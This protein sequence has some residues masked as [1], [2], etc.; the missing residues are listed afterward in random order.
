MENIDKVIEDPLIGAFL[1]KYPK[2]EWPD[3]LKKALKLGIYS[4]NTLNTLNHL[5]ISPVKSISIIDIDG[6]LDDES[7]TALADSLIKTQGT[8]ISSQ[9]GIQIQRNDSK[10]PNKKK[11]NLSQNSKSKVSRVTPKA[12]RSRF[13]FCKENKDNKRIKST[14]NK[15][16]IEKQ[17]LEFPKETPKSHEVMTVGLKKN[18]DDEKCKENNCAKSFK[19]LKNKGLEIQI[20]PKHHKLSSNGNKKILDMKNLSE[21]YKNSMSCRNQPTRFPLRVKKT[22]DMDPFVY[23]TSSSEEGSP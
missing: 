17:R 19:S 21:F 7:T 1:Q 6:G 4:M 18:K 12:N 10:L 11:K 5:T 22:L 16:K 8:T 23:I 14:K 3:V 15:Q 2:Q 13:E 20:S 9:E